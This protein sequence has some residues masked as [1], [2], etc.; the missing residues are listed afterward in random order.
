MILP[1]L[2]LRNLSYCYLSE[3]TDRLK[4]IEDTDFGLVALHTI[5]IKL[6][7]GAPYYG[8]QPACQAP[9]RRVTTPAKTFHG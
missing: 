8:E 5:V 3:V 9:N 6:A 4:Q 7:A 2:F 1:F